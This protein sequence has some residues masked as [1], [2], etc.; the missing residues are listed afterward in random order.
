R[1]VTAYYDG[2]PLARARI[3]IHGF[4]GAGVRG[5]TAR[6]DGG[7][8]I[9]VGVGR[10]STRDQ[11][12]RDWVLTHEMVHVVF[13]SLARRHHG[14]EEGLATYV[15]PL[16]RVRAGDL[17]ET[18]VWEDLVD[19]L[20]QGLP[21]DGDRGL[22]FTPTWGRTYWGGAL[23][24]LVADV[25]IRER[26]GNRKGLEHALRAIAAAGGTIETPW[27][28]DKVIAV[29][30]AATGVPVLREPYDRRKDRPAPV[31]LDELWR[32][33]GVRRGGGRI[34]FDPDAPL[35]AVRR[36]IGTGR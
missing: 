3:A 27:T 29:G 4:D 2:F 10:E 19:G 31:D 8:A 30:D 36:A 33:L 14:M 18:K 17:A 25:A 34:S 23:F 21:R 26:T 11:L 7:P 1:A 5:G 12:T 35:A 20:P 24:W 22:D 16:G 6:G 32:R 13:P 9:D 15:E 28:I